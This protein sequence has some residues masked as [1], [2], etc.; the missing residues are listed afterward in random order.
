MTTADLIKVLEQLPPD[1]NIYE[2]FFDAGILG[3]HGENDCFFFS[4]HDIKEDVDPIDI[5]NPADIE[6]L[7]EVLK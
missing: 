1:A 7:K 3:L 5:S 4:N 2:V 6:N